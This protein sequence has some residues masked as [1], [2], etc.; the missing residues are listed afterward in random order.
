MA[1]SKIYFTSD[2]H[3]GHEN[4]I[5]YCQ[6]PFANV[7]E[8]NAS[9]IANYNARV[10]DEDTCYFV[11][12]ICLGDRQVNLKLFQ[13]LRGTRILI[14]GNHDAVFRITDQPKARKHLELYMQAGFSEIHDHLVLHLPEF[15]RPIRLYH[16]PYIG[17]LVEDSQGHEARFSHYRIPDDGTLLL[18]GHTHQKERRSGPNSIHVGVD[19]W[20]YQIVSLAEIN[21][22]IQLPW[23]NS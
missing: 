13:Q 20:N 14:T 3:I 9:L 5:T 16:F 17:S 18:H 4:I 6:R 8:M 19:A 1:M 12:D 15:S 2:W 21:E 22:L 7:N 23:D 10:T 11:G